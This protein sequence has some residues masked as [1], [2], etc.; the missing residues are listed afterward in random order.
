MNDL[1]V[2]HYSAG[3][4][5]APHYHEAASLIVVVSG[6]YRETI[7]SSENEHDA[8]QMLFYPA[9]ATHSQRFGTAGARKIIF[10]PRTSSLQYLQEQ[11][12]S[13]DHARHVAARGMQQ[14]AARTLAELAHQDVFAPMA[15]DGI[16]LELV[17]T[18]ARGAAEDRHGTA[19]SW[20]R[21]V[22][23]WAHE[24]ADENLSI[25]DVAAE[26]AKHPVHVAREFRRH[27]GTTIGAYRRQVRVERSAAMLTANT[28]D[29]TDIA[30]SCGFAS[31]AHLC[32]SFKAAYGITP[33][34]FRAMRC[35]K[36]VKG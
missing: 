4:T 35:L 9:F 29:L 7:Q 20:V 13:I 6:C 33:S 2:A 25:D 36:R 19:P 3:S 34:E 15:L 5:M 21:A 31:H 30:L 10:T 23:D 14:L 11:G 16:L 17:A 27:Y 26:V 12:I 32:R 1:R 28:A 18:F 8:G 22:R 24:T